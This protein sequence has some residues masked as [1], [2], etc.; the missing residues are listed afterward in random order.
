MVAHVHRGR[1]VIAVEQLEPHKR[2]PGLVEQPDPVAQA[3]EEHAQPLDWAHDPRVASSANVPDRRGP[4]NIEWL[5]GGSAR[6]K[7]Y[8]RI[9]PVRPM[10]GSHRRPDDPIPVYRVKTRY[11]VNR[12]CVIHTR[13]RVTRYVQ[14]V[15]INARE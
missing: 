14:H 5:P 2:A 1:G 10:V 4:G 8:A 15:L 11:L 13:Q 6:V 7:V 9:D 12:L 3:N